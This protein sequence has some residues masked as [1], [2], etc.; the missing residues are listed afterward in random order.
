MDRYLFHCCSSSSIC[1]NGT[2]SLIFRNPG[3][4]SHMEH[5]QFHWDH[6]RGHR[7][8][9]RKKSKVET[10]WIK[11]LDHHHPHVHLSK[12]AGSWAEVVVSS[13][14]S[15]TAR[16]ACRAS[17][18]HVLPLKLLLLLRRPGSF[19]G[20]FLLRI[21]SKIWFFSRLENVKSFTWTNINKP[22]F[23]PRKTR[24]SR[25]FWHFKPTK[26]NLWGFL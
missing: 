5:P 23:T 9:C 19:N 2:M 12:V 26:Q 20:L 24:K 14:E 18:P 4:C 1:Q 25:H 13:N 11:I 16:P 15:E 22:D 17:S 6:T 10:S 8:G 21:L 7:Q 3:L